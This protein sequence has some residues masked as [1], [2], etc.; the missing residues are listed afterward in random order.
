MY[1]DIKGKTVVVTGGS[2]GIGKGIAKVFA[3]HGA[4]VAILSRTLSTAEQCVNELNQKQGTARAFKTDV[5]NRESIEETIEEVANAFGGIDIVCS[6]AGIFPQEEIET[7]T[8]EDW[9]LVI[10]TNVRGTHWTVKASIPYLKEAK[11]GRI[12][13]TSSITGPLVGYRGW[14]HY[15][16]SK[17][18]QLGYMKSAALELAEYGVT[19]NS[20]MPGNVATGGLEDLGDD[21]LETMTNAIPVGKLGNVED[22]GYAA[23]FFASENTS[24][25]TGQ[26]IVIDGGQTIPEDLQAK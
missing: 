18:A 17:A 25:I 13:F 15:G 23:M 1:N 8:D 19:V 2:K 7:M 16:A 12:I 21:Y 22:V 20:V 24:F 3:K 4:N 14:A 11:A 9:N 26:T 5:T 6:N 10:N